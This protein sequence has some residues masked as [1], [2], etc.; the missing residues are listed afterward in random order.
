M[1]EHTT[2]SLLERAL[3]LSRAVADVAK[4][5]TAGFVG[6]KWSLGLGYFKVCSG[7]CLEGR[8]QDWKQR[9]ARSSC[10]NAWETQSSLC[11]TWGDATV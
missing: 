3:C 4:L 8:E 9:L 1:L 2:L 7:C 6:T 10:C 5:G 11:P